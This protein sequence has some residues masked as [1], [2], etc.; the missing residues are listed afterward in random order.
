M[1]GTIT[2]GLSAL[3]GVDASTAMRIALLYGDIE[4][5][6]AGAA[7]PRPPG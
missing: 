3:L 6:A 2:R 1:P 4:W 5:L 7:A